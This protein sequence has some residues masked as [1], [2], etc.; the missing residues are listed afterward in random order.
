MNYLSLLNT[1]ER[2]YRLDMGYEFM[3]SLIEDLSSEEL[4]NEAER[5]KNEISTKNKE[6]KKIQTTKEEKTRKLDVLN[7]ILEMRESTILA[8]TEP[9]EDHIKL[10]KQM[11][12]EE[13][14]NGGDL[15]FIGCEGKRPFGSRNI[16]MDVA[17]IL[18]WKLPN[19]DLSDGQ[20][21]QADQ[22][23]KE[24]PFVINNIFKNL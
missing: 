14:K 10:L 8:K 7:R 11:Y 4:K 2:S 16:Y 9:N 18:E 1:S 21:K 17:E 5:L 24:L 3:W 15:V 12:F 13:F 20:R 22:L 6:Q 19:D 23:L